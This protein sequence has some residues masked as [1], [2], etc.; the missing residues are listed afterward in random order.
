MRTLGGYL[1][2][3]PALTAPMRSR[4]AASRHN[5]LE[6]AQQ[7]SIIRLASITEAFCADAL[8]EAAEVLGR[9]GSSATMR[10]IWE[11][12]VINATRTWSAQQ[13]AY[14]D[15]LNVKI[16]WAAIEDMATARNAIAHGLGSLTR[17]QLHNASSARTQLARLDIGL[18]GTD[19]VLTDQSVRGVAIKCKDVILD[20][21][22][23]IAGRLAL[24]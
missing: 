17:L 19:L 11:E 12:S 3:A 20:L 4:L 7:A 21:D 5:K 24:P 18:A 2:Q 16:K 1:S 9:P 15:W 13:K 22:A 23:Q 8:V 6:V 14:K 10:A